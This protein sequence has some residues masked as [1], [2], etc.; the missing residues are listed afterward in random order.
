MSDATDVEDVDGARPD[1][2]RGIMA[3]GCGV[4]GTTVC[5]EVVDRE[6]DD[7]DAEDTGEAER[8]DEGEGFAGVGVRGGN[9]GRRASMVSE[10]SACKDE[11]KR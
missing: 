8:G 2:A 7:E 6:E 5:V 10:N 4:R 1:I 9:D 3:F 11:E